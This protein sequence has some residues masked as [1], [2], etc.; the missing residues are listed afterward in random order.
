MKHG[1]P[2]T[3]GD[4]IAVRGKEASGKRVQ[5]FEGE[6][7]WKEASRSHA[8]G[9]RIEKRL[10]GKTRTELTANKHAIG[11]TKKKKVR[12]NLIFSAE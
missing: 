5:K 8:P 12:G 11:A 2:K 3:A 4:T 7:P 1:G 9:E 10:E 6:R